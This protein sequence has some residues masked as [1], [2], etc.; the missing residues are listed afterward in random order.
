VIENDRIATNYY[1]TLS[2]PV[3]TFSTSQLFPFQSV[4]PC[5]IN[6]YVLQLP[7][8]LNINKVPSPI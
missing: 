4:H 1:K 2:R 3:E 8:F 7:P 6:T 5:S